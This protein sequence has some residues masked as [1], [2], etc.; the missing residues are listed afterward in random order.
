MH[1]NFIATYC[2]KL[3]FI[4]YNESHSPPSVLLYDALEGRG[5]FTV[6]GKQLVVAP[7]P[8]AITQL[9]CWWHTR[10]LQDNNDNDVHVQYS[11]LNLTWSKLI[12]AV[13]RS[14]VPAPAL[15]LGTSNETKKSFKEKIKEVKSWDRTSVA[16]SPLFKPYSYR[17]SPNMSNGFLPN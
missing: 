10:Y 7:E 14:T 13:S 11:D 15:E 8:P 4:L 6:R 3:R 16:S 1:V 5:Y 17:P 9:I 12:K 2:H